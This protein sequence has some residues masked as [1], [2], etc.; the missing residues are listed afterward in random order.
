MIMS[1]QH[2]QAPPGQETDAMDSAESRRLLEAH[3]ER[4]QHYADTGKHA[5]QA[6]LNGDVEIIPTVIALENRRDPGLNLQLALSPSALLQ[7]IKIMPPVF[8]LRCVLRSSENTINGAHHL[9]A[10]IKREAN[11]PLSILMIEP[12]HLGNNQNGRAMLLALLILML[13]DAYFTGR[14]MSC[15][16]V[17]AQMSGSDCL[18]FC[19][20]FALKARRHEAKI[21]ALHAIH[22]SGR[23]IGND[24]AN[25][26][27]DTNNA[28]TLS[29]APATLLPF[30]FFEHAQSTTVMQALF[31]SDDPRVVEQVQRMLQSRPKKESQK[32]RQL[33]TQGVNTDDE[34]FVPSSI[35]LRRRRFLI[36]TLAALAVAGDQQQ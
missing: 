16:N 36:D 1:V 11:G 9:Y 3:L 22:F 19:I 8:H 29:V 18:I 32:D 17:G 31:G 7:R 10:D 21:A 6:M 5:D 34:E 26:E 12:A 15:F 4:V 23:A 20:D 33:Q 13:P 30:S 25:P 28:D 14:R 24:G 35:E 27:I 2:R